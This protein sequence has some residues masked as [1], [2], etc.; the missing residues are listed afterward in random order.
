MRKIVVMMQTTLN[1]RIAN[2]DGEFW[3]PFP[4]GEQEMAYLN[5]D[6]RDADTWALSR[7]L[8]EAIVPWWDTVA[9]GEVPDD[10]PLIS[11]A[12]REFAQLQKDMT[13]VVFS[14]TLEP[15]EDRT[16]VSG[17]LATELAALKEQD[18]TKIILSCARPPLGRSPT[19]AAW[20]TSTS[21]PCIPRS[22]R[23]VRGCS[24]AFPPISPWSS[25]SRRC[26]TAV[27]SS[28]VTG[29]SGHRAVC[30]CRSPQF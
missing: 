20:W 9:R 21:S 13:K 4:W 12:D 25:R 7:V 26:S 27:L 17:D 8:Y 3:E 24:M 11:A 29:P 6:F 2:A 15:N 16:V 28:C 23:L 5:Q 14:T 10:A 22:S 30:K 18:G 19:P 1:N